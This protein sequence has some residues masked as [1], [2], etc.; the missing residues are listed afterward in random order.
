[1]CSLLSQRKTGLVHFSKLRAKSWLQLLGL[2]TLLSSK[3]SLENSFGKQTHHRQTATTKD[4]PSTSW[5][6]LFSMPPDESSDLLFCSFWTSA[7]NASNTIR[8]KSLCNETAPL[9]NQTPNASWRFQPPPVP[10]PAQRAV[11][12][13]SSS[14]TFSWSWKPQL[15]GAVRCFF[16]LQH[17]R[18]F[19]FFWTQHTGVF[20][21]DSF[22]CHKKGNCYTLEYLPASAQVHP[23]NDEACFGIA[24]HHFLH[25]HIYQVSNR[26]CQLQSDGGCIHEGTAKANC[27]EMG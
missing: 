5:D 12:C 6:S 17:P 9:A 20:V 22:F 15:S 21:R 4:G 26:L 18:V 27:S 10:P 13:R 1:M 25:I 23:Y 2:T 24:Q 8:R 11:C 3:A 16:W 14:W 7:K 19:R